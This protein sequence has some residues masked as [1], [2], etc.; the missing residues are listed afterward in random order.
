MKEMANSLFNEIRHVYRC[1]R[2]RDYKRL[3]YLILKDLFYI[4][5][6]VKGYKKYRDLFYNAVTV[7]HV[8]GLKILNRRYDSIGKIYIDGEYIGVPDFL[9]RRG[10][11][12]VDVGANIG[13]YTLITAKLVGIEGKVIAIEPHPES[14]SLLRKN[15]EINR[16]SNVIALQVALSDKDYQ[17]VK[18]AEPEIA[19]VRYPVRASIVNTR[20]VKRYFLVKALT[21]DTL[22]N[23][24]SLKRIDVLKIDVEGAEILVLKGA[25]NTLRRLRPKI[26]VETHGS[27]NKEEVLSMLIKYNYKLVH[28]KKRVVNGEIYEYLYLTP[29]T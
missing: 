22:I 21:L 6:Y 5:R 29:Q 20:N 18:L 17:E 23:K 15:I 25:I 10:D 2:L 1:L 14:Y 11:V 12:V 13:E 24:L 9:P 26:C 3:A 19:G 27:H 8:Q 4:V 16:L 28:K 7:A